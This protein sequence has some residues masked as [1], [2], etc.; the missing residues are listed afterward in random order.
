MKEMKRK[1]QYNASESQMSVDHQFEMAGDV[2]IDIFTAKKRALK[3]N[4]EEFQDEPSRDSHTKLSDM[5]M[6]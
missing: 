3:A 6:L 4:Q 5:S 2:D 1:G